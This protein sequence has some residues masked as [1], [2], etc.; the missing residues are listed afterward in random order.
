[1]GQF[2]DV[3][4][5]NRFE[6]AFDDDKGSGLVWA[7]YAVKGDARMTLHVE[8]EQSLPAAQEHAVRLQ[9][10]RNAFFDLPEEQREALHL[11]AIEGLDYQA[12]AEVLGVPIGTLMSRIGRARAALRALEAGVPVPGRARL[13]LVGGADE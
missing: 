6:Q 2:K 1:M 7:D 10:V 4:G 3:E 12:A 9:Q 11:V 5:D 13:T 8:A